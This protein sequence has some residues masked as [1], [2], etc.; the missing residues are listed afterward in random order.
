MREKLEE[1]LK[2]TREQMGPDDKQTERIWRGVQS[3][4]KEKEKRFP[5][6]RA[7]A[8]GTC[9][10][11]L[12][13]VTGVSVN[14]ATDGAFFESVRAFVGMTEQQ[15]K[16]ADEGIKLGRRESNTYADPLVACSDAYIIFANERGLMIYGREE[17][18]LLA[19]LD[20]QALDC[21]YFNADTIETHIMMQE[22]L[23]YIFNE[24][25]DKNTEKVY[26]YDLTQA[27]LEN[28]LECVEDPA[29]VA[30]IQKQWNSYAAAYRRDTFDTIPAAQEEWNGSR[31]LTYSEY[32]IVWTD[33]K[34]AEQI[35]CL[36][37]NGDGTYELYTCSADDLS[38]ARTDTLALKGY[39]DST[40]EESLPKFVYTGD[41]PVLKALCDYMCKEDM[42]GRY[43]GDDEEN[44]VFIPAPVVYKTVTRGDELTVFA[45]LWS[46]IYKQNGNTLDCVSGG[47]QPSRLKLKPD[48]NGGY[49]IEE[50]LAAGDGA[51]YEKDIRDFC[52]GYM[53]SPGKFIEAGYKYEGIRK[54]LIRMYVDDNHLD[55]KYFKDYGWDPIALDDENE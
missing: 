15:E 5:V 7:A 17:Q 32:S 28:A 43:L 16:V 8:V 49:R 12:C 11:A 47:E 35:S 13:V 21:N 20:L 1:Q 4:T 40:Q 27:G 34:G 24:Y 48:G 45:N 14:A 42:G 31:D 36:L 41:D 19:A 23:L 2:H 33:G 3:R 53:I 38:D 10:L 52:A 54:E 44:G 9:V 55:I 39:E 26:T 30:G 18:T 46:Y 6:F 25:K 50:H 37:I 29:E 22:N 51:D